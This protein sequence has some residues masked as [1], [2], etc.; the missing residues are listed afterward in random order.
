[1]WQTKIISRGKTKRVVLFYFYET[2][3]RWHCI[4]EKRSLFL[5][6]FWTF[7]IGDEFYDWF[8]T[9]FRCQDQ[10]FQVQML[11]YIFNYSRVHCSI[12]NWNFIWLLNLHEEKKRQKYSL[13]DVILTIVMFLVYLSIK[14]YEITKSNSVTILSDVSKKL[15][16]NNSYVLP[17]I[18]A[19]WG[20]GDWGTREHRIFSLVII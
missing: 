9:L 3:F 18:C 8:H 19:I 15:T 2:S 4:T 17:R 5:N 16:T 12:A 10:S 6:V 1:M 14:L 13:N 7:A 11:I 20:R